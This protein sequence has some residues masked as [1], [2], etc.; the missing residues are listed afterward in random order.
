MPHLGPLPTGEISPKW[1]SEG[2]LKGDKQAGSRAWEKRKLGLFIR[3]RQAGRI[4]YNLQVSA[5]FLG[6]AD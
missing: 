1:D 6:S 3:E 5:E 4:S 2:S